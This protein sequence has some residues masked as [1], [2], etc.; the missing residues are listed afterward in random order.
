MLRELVG[1]ALPV[2]QR[3]DVEAHHGLHEG[4]MIGHARFDATGQLY[5]YRHGQH[6]TRGLIPVR[7]PLQDI[8]KDALGL[9]LCVETFGSKVMQ[10]DERTLADQ[11]IEL[12]K[13]EHDLWIVQ[14]D[15]FTEP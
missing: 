3:V 8:R 2:T 12:G 1:R 13:G 9:P 4:G 10:V 15:G 14:T 11:R 6:S 7:E 5:R